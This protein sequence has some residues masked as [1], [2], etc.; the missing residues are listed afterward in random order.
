MDPISLA[1]YSLVYNAFSF[2]IA[3]MGAATLFFLM[4]SVQVAPAYRTAITVTGLVT[5]IA[6]YHYFRIFD[7]WEAAYIVDNG[8]VKASGVAFHD[9]YRYVDWLLTVP[10]L[11]VELILVMRLPQQETISKGL[12]LGA[13][14]ALMVVLGY[15]GEVASND[16]TRWIWWALAMIPFLIIV[17][18]LFVGLR[19][20]I[21]SQPQSARGMVSAARWLTVGSWCFYPI[22]FIFPMIGLKGASALVAVQVGYTIAD[23]VAK[24]LFGVFIYLIAVRKSEAESTIHGM[25]AIQAAG[26]E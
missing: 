11:L 13:L 10:L 4:R 20:S 24:A 19:N 14:A 23:I 25:P 26:A 2:T 16:Q 22:V 3:I 9:A 5:L 18:D 6:C 1:Q 7:S 12:K 21:N 8:V 15:P 17:Y